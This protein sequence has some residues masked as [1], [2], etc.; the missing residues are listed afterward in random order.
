M[1]ATSTGEIH[2]ARISL[3]IRLA[4]GRRDDMIFVVDSG[5]YHAESSGEADKP[6]NHSGHRGHRE[7][8]RAASTPGVYA[9]TNLSNA[10]LLR[11]SRVEP[12]SCANSFSRNSP[13]T[14]VTVSRE[15]PIS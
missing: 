13:S 15:V 7:I 1:R 14:R 9:P 12:R 4:D 8:N 10:A 2:F 11:I 3:A 6:L 5:V